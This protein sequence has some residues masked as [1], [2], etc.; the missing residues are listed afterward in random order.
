M[1]NSYISSAGFDHVYFNINFY[2][3]VIRDE[4]NNQ[5]IHHSDNDC[6][7]FIRNNSHI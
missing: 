2:A 7:L 6:I 3:L 1:A 4:K 5:Y